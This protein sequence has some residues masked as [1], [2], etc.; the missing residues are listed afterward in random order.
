MKKEDLLLERLKSYVQSPAYPFHMPGHKRSKN[1]FCQEFSNPYE[2]DITEIEGFDNLHHP[3]GILQ[4]SMQWA[5]QIYGSDRTYYLINGS[6]SGILSAISSVCGFNDKII[7][8]RNCHKSVYHGIILKK[9]KTAYIYPQ[10]LKKM[11]ITGG[12]SD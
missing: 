1:S 12:I 7:I 5:S 4:D 6:S 9:L 11:W 8:S 10:I 2:I 3:E